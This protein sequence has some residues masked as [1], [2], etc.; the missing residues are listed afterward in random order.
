MPSGLIEKMCQAYI[1]A[2]GFTAH[3]IADPKRVEGMAAVLRVVADE[4][5]KVAK[6]DRPGDEET[7]AWYR[8]WNACRHQVQRIL[9]A[10][11]PSLKDNL[12]MILEDEIGHWDR[13][14][15]ATFRDKI[16]ALLKDGK[17]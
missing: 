14:T 15:L 17:R 3:P 4:M 5:P 13:S 6:D 2:G 9:T 8:G 10:D 16:L 12:D 7:A 11:E 1:K